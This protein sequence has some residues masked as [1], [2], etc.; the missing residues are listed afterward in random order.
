M[1]IEAD[2][3]VINKIQSLMSRSEKGAHESDQSYLSRQGEVNNSLS[4]AH[5]LMLEHGLIALDIAAA[6]GPVEKIIE[7]HTKLGRGS[8][9]NNEWYYRLASAVAKTCYTTY[10]FITDTAIVFIG[11]QVDVEASIMLYTS[12]SNQIADLCRI[13]RKIKNL[14]GGSSEYKKYTAEFMAGCVVRVAE[15]LELEIS[16]ENSTAGT[17]LVKVTEERNE[18]YLQSRHLNLKRTSARGVEMSKHYMEGHKVGN[19]VA[20]QEESKQIQ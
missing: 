16:R 14:K 12:L 13:A 6:G 3:R 8:S 9:F 19:R 1:T 4:L 10:Y 18:A 7:K 15:R 17:Q 20:L 2:Q 11:T 5:K